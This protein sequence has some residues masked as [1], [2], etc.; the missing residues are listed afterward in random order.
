MVQQAKSSVSRR[1]GL[2]PDQPAP[3]VACEKEASVHPEQPRAGDKPP[4][5]HA[6]VGHNYD[7]RNVLNA[8]KR[9][10][11]DGASRGY[12]PRRGGRYDS[13]ED[14]SPSPEPPRPQVFSQDTRN[15]L[16][17][18]WF[19]QPANITK[20]F[21]ETNPELWLDDY[22]LAYQLGDAD[23]D[24]FI[25][26]NLPLFSADSVRAWLEHLPTRRVHNWADLVKVFMG[27][28]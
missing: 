8:R 18:T 20:Y 3:S 15:T 25:I 6:H 10:K 22:R 17:P 28:F 7:A 9:H 13:R 26:C 14:R 11:E 19:W 27:N 21:G 24:R 16:F 4:S 1:H 23:D 12:H 2:E 5:V